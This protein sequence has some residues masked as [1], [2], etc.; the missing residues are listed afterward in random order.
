MN[1]EPGSRFILVLTDI[2]TQN[3]QTFSQSCFIHSTYLYT[4]KSQRDKTII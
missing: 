1:E 3:S 2:F 4:C